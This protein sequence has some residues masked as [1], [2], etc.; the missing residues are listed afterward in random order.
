MSSVK[1]AVVAATTRLFVEQ[2]TTVVAEAFGPT[3]VQHSAI[4]ADGIEGLNGLA[5]NLPEGFSYALS[6][7][8]ADDSLVV[9]HGVYTGFGPDPLVSFDV[10]RADNGRIVEHWDALTPQVTET[11][12]GHS[13]TD[14]TTEVRELDQTDANKK[15]VAE[16]AEKVLIGQDYSVLTDYISTETYIQHNPEA[17]DGLDGFGA[18]VGRWAEGGKNLVYKQVHQVVAEGNFVFT[19]AQGEF[20]VPVVYSDLWR[21]ENGKIVEHWDVVVPIPAE[22]PHTNGLF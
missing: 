19:R 10:F 1:E 4:A 2:D 20:G 14:G 13:Q 21:V 17:G 9:L 12:S 18:A 22:I 7:V 8:V 5:N 11:V 16:F 6:R 3:Y 15:L